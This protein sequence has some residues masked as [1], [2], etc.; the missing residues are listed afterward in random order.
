MDAIEKGLREELASVQKRLDMWEGRKQSLSGFVAEMAERKDVMRMD[1][2][3][4]SWLSLSVSG[5]KHSLAE[6]MRKLRAI[7]YKTTERP[8]PGVTS[9]NPL[10]KRESDGT[11]VFLMFSGTACRRVQ[12][13]TKTVEVPV[14]EVVCDEVVLDRSAEDD[15]AEAPP[16]AR[17]DEDI[18][19]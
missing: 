3:N 1:F 15:A 17:V 12:T 4:D 9:W 11:T 19:F 10:L 5:D 13:G 7:G 16:A 8:K 2:D 14:Y 6:V 18:P